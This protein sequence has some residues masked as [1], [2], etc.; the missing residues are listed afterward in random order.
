MPINS[1]NHNTKG[2]SLIKTVRLISIIPRNGKPFLH[3]TITLSMFNSLK[4][5][6]LILLS[7][8]HSIKRFD[9]KIIHDN[10]KRLVLSLVIDN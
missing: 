1:L 5:K 2:M 9:Y 3:S 6:K 7:N 8:F 10:Y 4:V